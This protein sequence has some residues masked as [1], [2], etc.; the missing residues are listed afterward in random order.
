[1]EGS[2]QEA[3]GLFTSEKYLQPLHDSGCASPATGWTPLTATLGRLW[4]EKAHSWGEFVFDQAFANAYEQRGQRYYPKRVCCVPFT[5]VPGPRLRSTEIA[6]LAEGEGAGSSHVL[7]LPDEEAAALLAR[8]W[9]RRTQARYVWRNRGYGAF[10]DFLGALNSKRRKNIRAERKAVA[11]SG[12]RIEWRAASSLSEAEW[13]EVFALYTRT[14]RVRGQQPYLK[15]ACLQAWAQNFPEQMLFCLARSESRIEAMAFFFRDGDALYGRHW[16]AAA[17]H[18]GLHFEL[19]CH[20]GIE[21][22]IREKLSFFDA[23]VQGEHKLLRGFEPAQTQ[24]MHWFAHPGFR[25]AIA[26]YLKRETAAMQQELE[27]LG[28]HDGYREAQ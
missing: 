27:Q 16:G 10:E 20:Q 6:A 11:T 7:F 15:L 23:G 24:S 13:R 28:E 22:A 2:I 5:P 9:L 25:A 18:D 8:G 1:M 4:Y 19:C 3:G 26:D 12:L 14:Y 21:Y 17:E